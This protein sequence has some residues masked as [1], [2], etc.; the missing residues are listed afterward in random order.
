MRTGRAKRLR[1]DGGP[2]RRLAVP[3]LRCRPR[4][5]GIQQGGAPLFGS[6]PCL[7]ATPSGAASRCFTPPSIC[8]RAVVEILRVRLKI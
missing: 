8:E 5:V 6:T 7:P 1:R 3:S 2:V 4:P